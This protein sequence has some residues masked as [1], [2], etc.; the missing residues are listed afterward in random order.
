MIRFIIFL[1]SCILTFHHVSNSQI[2]LNEICSFNGGILT[3]EDGD[4]S[5]W[6]EILN[7]GSSPVKSGKLFL[8]K[9]S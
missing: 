2:V 3:D 1:L 8:N 5:D 7:E 4:E 9:R 6:I